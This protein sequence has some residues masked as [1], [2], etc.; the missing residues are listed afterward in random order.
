MAHNN[1][2]YS[3]VAQSPITLLI[4]CNFNRFKMKDMFLLHSGARPYILNGFRATIAPPIMSSWRRAAADQSWL[5]SHSGV[6]ECSVNLWHAS[7]PTHPAAHL[8]S[9]LVKRASQCWEQP[10]EV[11]LDGGAATPLVWLRGCGEGTLTLGGRDGWVISLMRALDSVLNGS[12]WNHLHLFFV[13]S[14]RPVVI[15]GAVVK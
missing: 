12:V 15:F 13:V 2:F 11:R 4:K 7:G 14:T 3:I 10:A 5:F 9:L 1:N 8:L 6:R